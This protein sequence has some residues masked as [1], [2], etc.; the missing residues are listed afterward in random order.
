MKFSFLTLVAVPAI[1]LSACAVEEVPADSGLIRAEMESH[2]T[3]TT[4]TD[5]GVFT[6]SEGDQI[7]LHTT[8]GSVAGTLSSGAGTSSA[9][10]SYGAYIGEMT[11]KSVYPY[12]PGHTLSGNNL[13]VVL[14]AVYDLGSSLA[15]TNAAMYG[16]TVGGTIKFRHLAGV[17]RF[18]FKNVPVGTDKFQITLD[19]KINGVFAADLSANTP[20][21]EAEA[22]ENASEKTVTLNF[23]PLTSVSDICLYV[24]VPVGTYGS[25]G[26]DVW[27]GSE[28]VWSYSNTVTNTISRKSLVLMPS[29]TM[30]G[31]IS[32]DIDNGADEGGDDED[33]FY[34]ELVRDSDSEQNVSYTGSDVFVE[35]DT[36]L[37]LED[38]SADM[39]EDVRSWVTF[40]GVRQNGTD[41]AVSAIFEVEQNTGAQQ[42]QASIRLKSMTYAGL[43]I[44]IDLEQAAPQLA[45]VSQEIE[46]AC[47]IPF[48]GGCCEVNFNTDLTY[49]DLRVVVPGD[50]TWIN[51]I[52]VDRHNDT[53]VLIIDV[54]AN[55][56]IN[57]RSTTIE[58][59]SAFNSDICIRCHIEQE[60]KPKP[61]EDGVLPGIENE[62][63][64]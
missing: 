58:L 32:G 14:P 54:A 64:N 40:L 59:K 5:E 19:K 56:T 15:N 46:T 42:R 37:P 47:D 21:I 57:D 25:L 41:E 11:G 9:Q 18:K 34:L 62:D 23:D 30:P 50:V 52:F 48:T 2:D 10:F 51:N 24:P 43:Y 6:W 49:S 55:N 7:W 45:W 38:F 12:N 4:V 33:D 16:V 53:G 35:I 13:S 28:S 26:L 3:R 61:D 63:W 39:P 36:N 20:I 29:V 22:T 17:M 8:N 31:S 1:L 60:A 27:A 44:D